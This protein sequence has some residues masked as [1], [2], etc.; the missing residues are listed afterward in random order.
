MRLASGTLVF[1]TEGATVVADSGRTRRRTAVEERR[2]RRRGG[3]PV[4]SPLDLPSTRRSAT[5][6]SSSTSRSA[7]RR[8]R[9]TSSR[10]A[11][12]ALPD[13]LPAPLDALMPVPLGGVERRWAPPPSGLPGRPAAVLVLLYP[14][15]AGA[16]VVL[17]ER[18][19]R[20]RATIPAR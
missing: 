11:R 19:D 14:D 15:A 2:G 4:G 5:T 7:V 20:G 9:S 16:R 6:A 10:P 8:V 3:A 18:T 13:P 1:S 12:A 17:I